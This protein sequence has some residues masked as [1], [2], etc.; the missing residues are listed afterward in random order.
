MKTRSFIFDTLKAHL[1]ARG[2]TYKDLAQT[3]HTSE[4]TV[5]RIFA[6]QDCSLERLEQLCTLL[7]IELRDLIKSSPRPRK[8]V[9]Q[10]TTQ[11]ER[12]FAQNKKLLMMAI[13]VMGQWSFEDMVSHLTFGAKTCTEL[14]RHLDKMGFI[15]LQPR[16]RYRLLVARE[17]AWIP[18][19][20]I[21]RMV[22]ALADDYFNHSF[23]E[24]GEILKIINVRVSHASAQRLKDKLERIAQEYAD[25]VGSDAHLPLH[26]RPPLSICMAARAWIPAPMVEFIQPPDK[27]G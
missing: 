17:F 11:Q 25:Q 15:E 16:N 23:D 10:L 7:H 20:P 3:L 18:D 21:M 24:P 14:L 2:L 27:V 12:E 8:L 4:Q 26:E 19:G 22:K 5:K 1:K 13:C 6:T 9:Q